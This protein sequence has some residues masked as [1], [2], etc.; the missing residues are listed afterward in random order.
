MTS[1]EALLQ[2]QTNENDAGQVEVNEG[3]DLTEAG[4]QDE[5]ETEQQDDDDS[6]GVSTV[7]EKTSND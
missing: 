7:D 4:E 3:S 5:G 2:L 1:V 6:N